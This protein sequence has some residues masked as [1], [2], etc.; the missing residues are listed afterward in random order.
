MGAPWDHDEEDLRSAV[1]G[2]KT[3]GGVEFNVRRR[4]REIGGLR[5][6][7]LW[8]G[9][10]ESQREVARTVRQYTPD[11]PLREQDF[12]GGSHLLSLSAASGYLLAP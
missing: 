2:E 1:C 6:G 12:Q 4:A 9:D 7:A 10:E 5:A 3:G 11:P 8:G